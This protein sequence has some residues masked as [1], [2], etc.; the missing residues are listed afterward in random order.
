MLALHNKGFKKLNK[1]VLW[2]PKLKS[3]IICEKIC[4]KDEK[5]FQYLGHESLKGE[6]VTLKTVHNYNEIPETPTLQ[7]S[8][9][10]MQ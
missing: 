2:V 8:L 3:T 6:G 7:L 1:K 9:S 4:Q 5:Y 10:M